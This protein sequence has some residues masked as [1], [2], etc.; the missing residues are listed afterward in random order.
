MVYEG[1]GRP[2]VEG[3]VILV[4]QIALG[5]ALGLLLFKYWEIGV[6]L[7]GICAVAAAVYWAVKQEG[8]IEGAAILALICMMLR[9][10]Y[11]AWIGEYGGVRTIWMTLVVAFVYFLAWSLATFGW[12]ADPYHI[13]FWLVLIGGFWLLRI[14]DSRNEFWKIK[15]NRKRT[16]GL[17]T[18]AALM[19]SV[20]VLYKFGEIPKVLV[21]F[22]VTIVLGLAYSVSRV[23][24]QP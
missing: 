4:L 9:E 3:Q 20:L 15:A 17:A 19:V 10:I 11:L 21:S 6:V 13:G 8:L 14:T 18:F 22:G 23:L 16:L 2:P 1:I 5:V 7:V 24:A 12:N